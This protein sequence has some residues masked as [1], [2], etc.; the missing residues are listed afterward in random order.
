MSDSGTKNG[1]SSKRTMTLTSITIPQ[2]L[3]YIGD[4]SFAYLAS[5]ETIILPA[6][7]KKINASAFMKCTA[8]KTIYVPANKTGYYKKRLPEALHALIVE[9]DPVKKEKK[10]I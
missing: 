2:G 1:P 10:K 9:L 6:G 5:L 8:L 7:V 4:E 3:E